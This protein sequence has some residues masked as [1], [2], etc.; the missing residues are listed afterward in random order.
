MSPDNSSKQPLR[1]GIA[2]LGVVGGETARQLSHRGAEIAAVAGRSFTITAVSARSRTADR[3]FDM[4]GIA[5]VED[6]AD[7][8][9]RDDVDIVVEMIGGESGV[10]LDLVRASLQAGKHVVTANKALLAHHGAE[11]AALAE[12]TGVGLMFEAA[13]AGGIPAVK[14]LRE[15]LSGNRVSRVSGILNGTCNY[16]LTRMEK[17]GEAFADVLADA[18]KLG[19]AEAEPSLD[20]DGIDAAHKLTI[21]AAIAF[22]QTPQFDQVAISGIRDVSAVDFAYAAQLGFRIKLVG[23]AEPGRMPRMQTC[24]LP[25]STQL[26]KV[27]GVLNAVAFEGEPVGATVLTGPGAGAGPTSSAVLSDLVDIASGRIPHSFGRPVADLQDGAEVENGAGPDTPFYVRLMVVD[28]PGVL[29]DV[30]S[31]LQ[32]HGISVESLLQQ[33][34]APQDVVALVMTTHEV[35]VERLMSALSEIEA[36]SCVQAPPVAMPILVADQEG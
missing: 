7:I 5:W 12:E 3:G 9:A 24:L 25:M 31:V 34:R 33:G 20:V 11:L 13:V 29:A 30:T 28:K 22:G 26:A 2:G 8:A 32:I 18:Q 35:R 10:A 1:V 21:L 4:S 17:T 14:A 6:A 16:I 36:L 27:D 15:G 23:V 19:Y